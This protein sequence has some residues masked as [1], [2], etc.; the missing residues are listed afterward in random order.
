MILSYRQVHLSLLQPAKKSNTKELDCE[1][2]SYFSVKVSDDTVMNG[3]QLT[4][5]ARSCKLQIL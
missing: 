3:D 2:L 5:S 4:H 1:L